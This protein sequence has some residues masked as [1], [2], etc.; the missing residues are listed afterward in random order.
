MTL[1]TT[2]I[3]CDNCNIAEITVHKPIVMSKTVLVLEN[4]PVTRSGTESLPEV[5]L[6]D[7]FEKIY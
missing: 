3:A 6:R 4:T 5:F 1:S 2:A 7:T